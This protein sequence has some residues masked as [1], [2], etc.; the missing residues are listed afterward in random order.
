MSTNTQQN[1]KTM[2]AQHQDQRPGIESE[3]HPRPEFEKPEYKAA[4]KLTGKV[5]LI[6]GGTVGS[7]V[8]LLLRMPRKARMS[9]LYI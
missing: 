4:G 3:M 7:D 5:A 6:T 8:L 2:P 9:P 1:Q